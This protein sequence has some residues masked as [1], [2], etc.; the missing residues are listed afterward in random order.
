MHCDA[1]AKNHCIRHVISSGWRQRLGNFGLDDK[2]FQ[3][4]IPLLMA[5]KGHAQEDPGL[6]Q[7]RQE[8]RAFSNQ[9]D[10]PSIPE[11]ILILLCKDG[12]STSCE[13][14]LPPHLA[15]DLVE[16]VSMLDLLISPH[17][18]GIAS[19]PSLQSFS[20][21]LTTKM[22]N[23]AT[24]LPFQT[25]HG[26]HFMNGFK[27]RMVSSRGKLDVAVVNVTV[28]MGTRTFSNIYSERKQVRKVIIHKDYKPPHLGSDLS[29]LLLATP[30][31]FTNF[32][33][34]VCLQE[35]ERTWDRNCSVELLERRLKS[36]QVS[37]PCEFVIRWTL[38]ACQS[39]MLI[40]C[41]LVTAGG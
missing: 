11:T 41:G 19:S 27:S 40:T 8:Q 20:L 1:P 28:V 34:P 10:K 39:S 26:Y 16:I 17:S 23:V 15:I 29:L 24:G 37:T 2:M 9:E 6:C 3:L 36:P 33:M 22:F 4:L 38:V 5:L 18:L 32:K 35:E 25:R 14:E 7:A 12:S 21:I 13:T 30:V 31:Q